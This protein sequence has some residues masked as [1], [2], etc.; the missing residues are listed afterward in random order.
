MSKSSISGVDFVL[1]ALPITAIVLILAVIALNYFA[2]QIEKWG[3]KNIK[4]Q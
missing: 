2:P 1:W 3:R 4:K